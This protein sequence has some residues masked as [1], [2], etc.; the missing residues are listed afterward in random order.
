MENI[1][2]KLIFKQEF[3]SFFEG[4]FEFSRRNNQKGLKK[5]V[6]LGVIEFILAIVFVGFGI[7]KG[8]MD[9]LQI[10]AFAVL[11]F[12]LSLF[13]ILF[14]PIFYK[15]MLRKAIFK[16]FNQYN[17]SETEVTIELNEQGVTELSPISMASGE[18]EKIEA[19]IEIMSCYIIVVGK[20]ISIIIPRAKISNE[21]NIRLKEILTEKCKEN[22]K[23][24]IEKLKA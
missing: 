19:V 3:E 21:E 13:S 1:N 6:I 15:K 18:W 24:Y 11:M 23:Q 20:L 2:L 7:Y 22:N 17:L 4:S 12:I 9:N 10:I 14:Y 16:T 8:Q 5:M